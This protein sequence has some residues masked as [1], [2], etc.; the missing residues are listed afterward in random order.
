M[1]YFVYLL[2][3]SVSGVSLVFCQLYVM[4]QVWV[5]TPTKW[6]LVLFVFASPDEPTIII[7]TKEAS[8][9]CELPMFRVAGTGTSWR[10]LKPHDERRGDALV[11]FSFFI[12]PSTTTMNDTTLPIKSNNNNKRS[13]S[14]STQPRNKQGLR[15]GFGLHDWMQLL[16]H[17][18]DLAQRRGAPI[19]RDIT[20][21]EVRRHNKPYDGWMILRGKVYNIAPYLAYHPGGS[22]ILEKCLGKD[23]TVLFDKYHSWVNLDGLIGPLM[24]GYLKIEKKSSSDDDDESD[25][26]Y[27]KKRE[28]S[29]NNGAGYTRGSNIVLPSSS[30]SNCEKT[31]DVDFE[32]PKPRPPK[33]SSVPSL[34][35]AND[36]DNEE[37]K[38]EDELL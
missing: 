6:L 7:V 15:P 36:G 16:R 35:G 8:K 31:Q 13:S 2:L 37:E 4:V 32:M 3:F 12:F 18:K 29:T 27:L 20:I 34:L 14:S 11:F 28:I 33:G 22:E 26:G 24:L 30:S 38:E 1:F 21:D 10:C 9:K 19:R 17:A 25:G 5:K 23:G